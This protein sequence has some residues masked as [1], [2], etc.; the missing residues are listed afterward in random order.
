MEQRDQLQRTAKAMKCLSDFKQSITTK[1]AFR[2]A[3]LG[4][5]DLHGPNMRQ[6]HHITQEFGLSSERRTRLQH[7]VAGMVGDQLILVLS[8]SNHKPYYLPS[9]LA[10]P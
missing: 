3:L 4:C 7:R 5:K 10:F 6:I 8:Q 1:R 9:L 2:G